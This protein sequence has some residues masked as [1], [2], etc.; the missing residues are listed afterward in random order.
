MPLSKHESIH[1]V[2]TFRC[3][4]DA[5][6]IENGL[7]T[8]LLARND[9]EERNTEKVLS[10]QSFRWWPEL[11]RYSVSLKAVARKGMIG[12]RLSHCGLVLIARSA[13]LWAVR[14]SDHPRT[15]VSANSPIPP[16]FRGSPLAP[17]GPSRSSNSPLWNRT[18][19]PAA[20]GT[21]FSGRAG[22]ESGAQSARSGLLGSVHLGLDAA[23][24]S[25]QD[26]TAL[27]LPAVSRTGTR[28]HD[29][30]SLASV[31]SLVSITPLY[32]E[33]YLY[34]SH[35]PPWSFHPSVCSGHILLY[36]RVF[37]AV[38]M[39]LRLFSVRQA[40]AGSF[41]SSLC[42]HARSSVLLVPAMSITFQPII[43]H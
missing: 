31:V 36:W 22:A 42:R 32:I 6:R 33:V 8:S 10:C 2:G 35:C 41:G 26:R 37:C 25:Q 27:M 39:V 12:V 4:R 21:P 14:K 11:R 23:V 24:R 40:S 16:C 19:A 17:S 29:S 15:R 38:R 9:T 28:N 7:T 13:A 34:R 3:M 1:L 18:P 30:S 5:G 20:S 43:G